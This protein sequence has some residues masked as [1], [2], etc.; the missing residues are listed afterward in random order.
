VRLVA[1]RTLRRCVLNRTEPAPAPNA[2]ACVAVLVHLVRTVEGL[3]YAAP[4]LATKPELRQIIE[5]AR[6][7]IAG[8]PLE[9]VLCAQCGWIG[10][11]PVATPGAFKC[12]L[13]GHAKGEALP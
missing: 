1:L 7:A 11:F 4:I 8:K 10:M 3:H 13:C 5:A 6:H 9:K 12:A 2:A